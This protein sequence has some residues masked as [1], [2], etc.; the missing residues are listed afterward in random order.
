MT[1]HA[2]TAALVG[3]HV[4]TLSLGPHVVE[5]W[6]VPGLLD[7]DGES[8]HGC[9]DPNSKII[10]INGSD[11]PAVKTTTLLHEKLHAISDTYGLGLDEQAVATLEA[12][13]YQM[14]T[15]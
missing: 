9:W 2:K 10:L 8:L 4:E 11:Q 1:K 12:G 15:R 6:E 14:G 3:T 7:E 5:V 13:L